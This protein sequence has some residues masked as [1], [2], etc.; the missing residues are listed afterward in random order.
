MADPDVAS[1]CFVSSRPKHPGSTGLSPNRSP[2]RC[3]LNVL[4]VPA[5]SPRWS[6]L[7]A[8]GAPSCRT[9]PGPHHLA[10]LAMLQWRSP[11]T[12]P[13]TARCTASGARWCTRCAGGSYPAR[14]WRCRCAALSG[15]RNVTDCF[16]WA[17]CAL[18]PQTADE[19]HSPVPAAQAAWTTHTLLQSAR[20]VFPGTMH[21]PV[22][23]LHDC[24]LTH[25]AP[26]TTCAAVLRRGGCP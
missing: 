4:P 3:A 9:D 14:Q 12:Q 10:R 15:G 16:A 24:A 17:V 22:R 19:T 25:A 1:A 5:H 6:G 2:T 20:N 13:M 18:H 8:R 11:P 23:A 21:F 7:R 26:C